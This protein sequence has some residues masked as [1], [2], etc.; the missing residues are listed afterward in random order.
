MEIAV[1]IL[2]FAKS[3]RMIILVIVELITVNI[4]AIIPVYSVRTIIII[5]RTVAISVAQIHKLKLKKINYAMI[6]N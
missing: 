5:L 2:I 4:A 3:S 1:Q 6:V